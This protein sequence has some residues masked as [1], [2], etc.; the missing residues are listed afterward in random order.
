[1]EKNLNVSS[2]IKYIETDSRS[3]KT[4]MELTFKSLVLSCLT[5]YAFKKMYI[6]MRSFYS[7]WYAQRLNKYFND[8]QTIIELTSLKNHLIKNKLEK[9]QKINILPIHILE[10]GYCGSNFSFYPNYSILTLSN[11][12]DQLE[13][14]IKEEFKNFEKKL[15]LSSRTNLS[16]RLNQIKSDSIDFIISTHYL[17]C[18]NNEINQLL[19]EIHRVLKP[20]LISIF[21]QFF[22]YNLNF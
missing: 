12:F 4:K 19:D 5:L 8:Q 10:I 1:M 15:W 14:F 11:S 13:S 2:L 18:V 7:K 22:K 20:V 17:C 21:F 6:V 9:Y 16:I 3:I